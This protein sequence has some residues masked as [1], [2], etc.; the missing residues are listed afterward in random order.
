MTSS[1]SVQNCS[2]VHCQ[3]VLI[4]SNCLCESSSPHADPSMGD[5]GLGKTDT[6]YE[7]QEAASSVLRIK[8]DIG[9]VV[10]KSCAVFRSTGTS[11]D[12]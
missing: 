10:S 12:T 8:I 2:R 1:G 6:F 3:E 5:Q 4:Q 9:K 11:K 7:G